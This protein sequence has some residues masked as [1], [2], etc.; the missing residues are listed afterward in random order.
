MIYARAHDQTVADDYFA[1]MERV[2]K[3]LQIL[4]SEENIE[5]VNVQVVQ[6]LQKLEQ[7]E[8]CFEERALL[9]HQLREAFGRVGEYSLREK[10]NR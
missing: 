8:L 7:P 3:K 4:P 2:E 9:V 10:S 6:A 5:D 1:A